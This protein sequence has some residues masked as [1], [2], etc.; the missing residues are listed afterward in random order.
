V[1]LLC[2]G[3]VSVLYFGLCDICGYFALFGFVSVLYFGLRDICGYLCLYFVSGLC[4]C[5]ISDYADVKENTKP[6]FIVKATLTIPVKEH[7]YNTAS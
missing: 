4:L 2:F 7:T 1:S 3:F 6:P 5:F